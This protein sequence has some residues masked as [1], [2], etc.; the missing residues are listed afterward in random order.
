MVQRCSWL[1]HGGDEFMFLVEHLD[2]PLTPIDC[3]PHLVGKTKWFDA[4]WLANANDLNKSEF[5][6]H[7]RFVPVNRA[8][9]RRAFAIQF[10]QRR[11]EQ[12]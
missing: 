12:Y 2:K 11:V 4:K 9:S 6:Y 3:Q 10:R 7:G 1:G 8:V 5:L